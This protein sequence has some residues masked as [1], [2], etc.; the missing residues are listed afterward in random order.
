MMYIWRQRTLRATVVLLFTSALLIGP[1]LL[2]VSASWPFIGGLVGLGLALGAIRSRLVTLPRLL[3]HDLGMYAQDLWLGPVGGAVLI[4][5]IAPAGSPG[6]LQSIGGLAGLVG[7][8]N[9]FVR[10]LYFFVYRQVRRL[11][12]DQEP[13][14][15]TADATDRIPQHRDDSGIERTDGDGASSEST[16]Q[17]HEPAQRRDSPSKSGTDSQPRYD[18]ADHIVQEEDTSRQ[19]RDVDNP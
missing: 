17:T 2:G 7:M 1:A 16:L 14:Q 15:R 8:V 6:E 19:D 13:R 12:R 18:D 4:A 9:Y 10:P 11:L 3:G 5:G